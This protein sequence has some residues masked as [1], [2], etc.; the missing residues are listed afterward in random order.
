MAWVESLNLFVW[1]RLAQ[2]AGP[3][4]TSHG[5]R[6]DCLKSAGIAAAYIRRKVFDEIKQ[7]PWRLALG[8]VEANLR[9]LDASQDDISDTFAAS[10]RALLRVG[11]DPAKVKQAILLLR[12][13]PFSTVHV[14]QSHGSLAVLHRFH[15]AYTCEQL[16]QR[17]MLH[18]AR[19]LFTQSEDERRIERHLQRL[20]C[21]QRK[22][23]GTIFATQVFMASFM[24]EVKSG[25]LAD[26]SMP[27]A[28]RTAVMKQHA[29]LFERL[30]PEQRAIFE[31][32]ARVLLQKKARGL[33][34]T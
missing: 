17:A 5:L 11:Y 25:L 29:R 4:V 30:S 12:E 9:E 18:Q 10:V 32:D 22:Q 2:V 7:Y 28:L 27:L 33:Q 3:E 14:E 1:D 21:L 16:C 23:T 31:E 26:S 24:R 13:C 6:S 8:D 15:R 20:E 19:H 34:E